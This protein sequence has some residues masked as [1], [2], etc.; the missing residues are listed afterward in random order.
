MRR[1]SRSGLALLLLL[2][3]CG[4]VDFR[5]D[6][7][8]LKSGKQ[9]AWTYD[10]AG[11][12]YADDPA[13]GL[14]YADLKGWAASTL[15]RGGKD[16]APLAAQVPAD[17]RLSQAMAVTVWDL[18]GPMIISKEK[19]QA[20]RA[21]ALP[22]LEKNEAAIAKISRETQ[23]ATTIDAQIAALFKEHAFWLERRADRPQRLPTSLDDEI[24]ILSI[25]LNERLA[26]FKLKLNER[27]AIEKLEPVLDQLDPKLIIDFSTATPTAFGRQL[28]AYNRYFD[29]NPDFQDRVLA[30]LEAIVAQDKRLGGL[31][32]NEYD[33]IALSQ[34][35]A[36]RFG[37]IVRCLDGVWKPLR[38]D[39]PVLVN[40]RRQRVGL[41][42]L[43]SADPGKEAIGQACK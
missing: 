22:L 36:Q 11:L 35:R 4:C 30:K 13:T 19:Y 34:G 6:L 24:E 42:P 14:L 26:N 43:E 31:Y 38:L 15:H 41:P 21:R 3:L 8:D 5:A 18:G 32:A 20:A 39:N 17:I 12:A 40:E 7:D 23:S 28:L 37:T 25:G 9:N 33:A 29:A 1:H 27:Y 2:A 16:A 10:Y